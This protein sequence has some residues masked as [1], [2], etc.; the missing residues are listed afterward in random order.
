MTDVAEVELMC[1]CGARL[2]VW[3]TPNAVRYAAASFAV[4][5]SG[6]NCSA[7][8]LHESMPAGVGT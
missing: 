4:V 8:R 3:G 5:H 1:R 6:G 7:V 2:R